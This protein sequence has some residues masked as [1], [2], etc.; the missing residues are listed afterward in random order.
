MKNLIAFDLDGT[1][2]MS[3]QPIDPEIATL[4]AR[5]MGSLNV[6]IMSGGDWPQFQ[7]QL[8]AHLP[9]DCDLSRLF[10]L[11]TSGAKLYRHDGQWRQIYAEI[12]SDAERVRIT[13]A[14]DTVITALGLSNEPGWEPRIEDRGSQITLSALGQGAPLEAKRAW[15]PDFS[16]RRHIQSML[17]PMIPGFSVHVGGSTSV[18]ITRD[19]VDKGYGIVRLS[20]A[21]GIPLRAILFIGDALYPGGNDYA[22]FETGVDTIAVRDIEQTKRIIE[23]ILLCRS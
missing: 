19:G 5:L 17:A 4:L 12:L 9:D 20:Q 3:K 2:A 22:V 18:D 6:A 23:T 7:A 13:A 16:R 21:A 15:D 10:L 11:P 14:L 8:I 1:L